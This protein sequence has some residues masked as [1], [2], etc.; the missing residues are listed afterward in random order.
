M[1]WC[2]TVEIDHGSA[3]PGVAMLVRSA[4]RVLV[5]P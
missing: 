3:I 2:K 5:L 1:A 4:A